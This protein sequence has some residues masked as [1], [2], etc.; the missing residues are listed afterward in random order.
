MPSSIYRQHLDANQANFAAL[1]PLSFLARAAAIYPDKTAVIHG[2]RRFSYGEFRDRCH[3]LASALVRRG[4]G[5]GDTVAVMAP[6]VPAMLE[7]HYGVPMV[8]AVLNCLN[9]RL[10]ASAIA[11]CL[12]HGEAKLLIADTE[13]ADIIEGALRQ[14]DRRIPVIDIVDAL[15]GAGRRIAETDYEGLLG[16]GDPAFQP[17]P[18]AEEWSAISL[19]YTSGTTGNPKGVVCHHRGAACWTVV[20]YECSQRS[21]SRNTVSPLLAQLFP[22]RTFP[23][24]TYSDSFLLESSRIHRSC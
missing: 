1:T 4:I 12:A 16:E 2:E 8:G 13:Y 20:G 21:S 7:A 10:D 19:G 18:L 22:L 15:S 6:N 5:E 14:L 3:R 24:A 23:G 17:A 11:F 9:T